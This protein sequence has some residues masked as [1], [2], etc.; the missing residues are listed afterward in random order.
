MRKIILLLLIPVLF[1]S[2]KK[3]YDDYLDICLANAYDQKVVVK[4]LFSDYTLKSGEILILSSFQSHGF[5][6]HINQERTWNLT[7]FEPAESFTI[8]AENGTV[9]RSWTKD[10]TGPDS[11]FVY[12]NWSSDE[13]VDS[14]IEGGLMAGL[15]YTFLISEYTRTKHNLTFV[16]APAN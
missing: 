15:A 13:K 9:L 4:G 10:D 12:S 14:G 3:D 2:C 6:N 7:F 8:C 5:G 11:P 16:L 1:A